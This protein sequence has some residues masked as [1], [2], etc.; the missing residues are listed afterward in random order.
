MNPR[1][2]RERFWT[3]FGIAVP[4]AGAVILFFS[5][6]LPFEDWLA[7]PAQYLTASVA[8]SDV[9]SL[10]NEARITN[11][12]P[13]LAVSPLLTQAAQLKAE[14]MARNSYY[15]HE[16]PEGKSPLYWLD[17]VGYNYLNA[18]ENLVIDR[19][20][21]LQAVNAWMNSPDHRENILRP[22]FTQFGIGVAEGEY[23]GIHTIF[24]VQEFGT[25]YP[26]F[27]AKPVK[28]VA[29]VNTAPLASIPS[30]PSV[31][32]PAA[33]THIAALS[34]VKAAVV[35]NA[36]S[37]TS[38][39]AAHASS[40]AS[41]TAGQGTST[42]S[43]ALAPEFYAPVTLSA[44]QEAQDTAHPAAPESDSVSRLSVWVGHI[45]LYLRNILRF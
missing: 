17:L 3:L 36:T 39:P 14:D 8:A 19:T 43:F 40:T 33:I 44:R 28:K 20:T 4:I 21:A 2:S 25:P 11:G 38:V 13:P 22:Q 12:L 34:Q 1:I 37:S 27:A 7:I 42:V 5:G 15:A 18:G 24:V 30:V 32:V 41:S 23:Q 9:A 29:K 26:T 16:S 31:P 45:K 6:I 35:P 10:T